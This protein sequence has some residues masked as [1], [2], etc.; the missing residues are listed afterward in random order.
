MS[1]IGNLRSRRV[2]RAEKTQLFGDFLGSGKS[3]KPEKEPIE[4]RRVV[5]PRLITKR[6]KILV[7][8]A[9]VVEYLHRC[10]SILPP[11]QSRHFE[12]GLVNRLQSRSRQFAL[13]SQMGFLQS[14]DPSALST[15]FAFVTMAYGVR[16]PDTVHRP[17]VRAVSE[18]FSGR[19]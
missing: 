1:S 18:P 15:N 17:V 10:T 13:A 7:G 11:G 4:Q 14:Q 16:A 19:Q 2:S 9:D 6:S 8:L 5:A 12:A 3:K